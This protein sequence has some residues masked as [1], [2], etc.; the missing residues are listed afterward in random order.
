VLPG[1]VAVPR[2]SP[3]FPGRPI[4]GLFTTRPVLSFAICNNG[5]YLLRRRLT[6]RHSK[7]HSA[8]I[9]SVSVAALA[10]DDLK[11]HHHPRAFYYGGLDS[12]HASCSNCLRQQHHLFQRCACS[13]R[14]LRHEDTKHCDPSSGRHSF[15]AT[16]AAV[17]ANICGCPT[18]DSSSHN[19]T[20]RTSS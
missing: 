20:G 17:T 19:A 13:I 9:F 12:R 1:P 18:T 15:D 5:A 8:Y 11:E 7:V 16:A 3:H 4:A 6:F 14:I 10:P 2:P